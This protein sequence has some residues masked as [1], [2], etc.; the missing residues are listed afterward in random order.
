[1]ST[2]SIAIGA[3][4]PAGL[5]L[6]WCLYSSIGLVAGLDDRFDDERSKAL[7]SIGE[8]FEPTRGA[9]EGARD[10]GFAN[11]PGRIEGAYF[12]A[13]YALAPIRV[14]KNL[15]HRL[16]VAHFET[17]AALKKFVRTQAV[18]VVARFPGGVVVLRNPAAP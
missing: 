8:V 3:W 14:H 9:L 4:V 18:E 12:Q 1:M 17:T 11:Q 5:I 6:G 7:S 2:T 13:Q 15:D 10:V 16:I